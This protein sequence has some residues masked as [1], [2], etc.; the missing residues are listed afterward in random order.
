MIR[1]IRTLRMLS[2]ILLRSFGCL[3]AWEID[4]R[5]QDAM[6][7]PLEIIVHFWTMM[8]NGVFRCS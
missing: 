3:H 2:I 4:A 1:Q 7:W 8:W 6:K 5:V